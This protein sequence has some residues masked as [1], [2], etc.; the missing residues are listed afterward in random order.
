MGEIK[1]QLAA[2]AA[3][4]EAAMVAKAT[5]PRLSQAAVPQEMAA[6]LERIETMLVAYASQG[7]RGQ[8][9][10]QFRV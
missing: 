3:V 1:N 2:E 10:S 7:D 6:R 4:D 5:A 9:Q 8:L